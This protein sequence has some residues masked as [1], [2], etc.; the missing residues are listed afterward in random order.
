MSIHLPLV[1][2]KFSVPLNSVTPIRTTAR[3]KAWN[4]LTLS[5]AGI[6]GS[7]PSWDIDVCVRLLRVCAVLCA[8]SGLAL[9]WSPIQE[10]LPTVW[11]D[12]ETEKAAKV[13][14]IV[15]EP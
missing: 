9:G 7:N 10:I 8:G 12:Q 2:P 5:N 4:V 1:E 13:Q 6:V 11:K 15:V 14:Q 3:C